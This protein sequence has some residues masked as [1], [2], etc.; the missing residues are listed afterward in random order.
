[1]PMYPGLTGCLGIFCCSRETLEVLSMINDRDIAILLAL[2]RYYVLNT[3]QIKRLI[4]T[5]LPDGRVARRRLQTLADAHLVNRQNVQVCSAT[6]QSP[7]LV[8][9]PSRGGCEFLR[10]HFGD[11]NYLLTPTRTPIPHHVQHWLAVSDTHIA[12]DTAI[13]LQNRSDSEGSLDR[14]KPIDTFR[15]LFGRILQIDDNVINPPSSDIAIDGW[16]NEWDVANK[17]EADYSKH[18]KL[19][20]LIRQTPKLVCVPDAAFLLSKD[21]HKKVHYVEQDRA[22]S[23]VE[24][25]VAQ[26]TPGYA[27]MAEDNLHTRHFPESTIPTFSVLMIAP[28]PSR[29]DSLR[30]AMKGKPSA[31]RWRFV[32]TADMRPETLLSAP[33]FYPCEGEP[34]PLLKQ[35]EGVQHAL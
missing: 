28:T 7:P 33:I 14:A 8:Y 35:K 18:F 30:K 17:Q 25:V 10:S 6:N 1:M 29:R 15:L 16:L 20:T 3:S 32:A 2:V 12:F 27:A 4:F 22:T 24:Q 34:R 31:D 23:G 11:D 21:G 9:Y 19:Y 13:A 26:K 5:N